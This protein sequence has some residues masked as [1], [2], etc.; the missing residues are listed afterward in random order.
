MVLVNSANAM[1]RGF[2]EE[3]ESI[4][5]ALWIGGPGETGMNAVARALTVR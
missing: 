1:E 5:A 4:D 3:Y 2:L